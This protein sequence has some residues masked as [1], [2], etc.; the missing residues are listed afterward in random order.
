MLRMMFGAHRRR[1]D[2]NLTET[3]ADSPTANAENHELEPWPEFDK[4]VT[5]RSED[6]LDKLGMDD[7]FSLHRSR[8]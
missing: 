4:R 5:H 6:S 2:F 3:N 1:I 7:W 8:K